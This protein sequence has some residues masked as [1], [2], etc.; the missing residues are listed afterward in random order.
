MKTFL[1]ATSVLVGLVG[2]ICGL[3]QATFAYDLKISH[4]EARDTLLEMLKDPAMN[5]GE[6]KGESKLIQ[7]LHSYRTQ[8][9]P[10]TPVIQDGPF[11]GFVLQN[12]IVSGWSDIYD[13]QYQDE[14]KKNVTDITYGGMLDILMQ[15]IESGKLPDEIK[16]VGEQ[17]GMC[18]AKKVEAADESCKLD[19]SDTIPK[20][21]SILKLGWMK[22]TCDMPVLSAT[23]SPC[24]ARKAIFAFAQTGIVRV[25][26][27]PEP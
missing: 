14:Y 21:P 13:G 22:Y 6:A 1:Q 5:S 2:T 7:V 24:N 25:V 16:G 20:K 4:G 26:I 3:A 19:N 8:Q 15:A 18:L 9:S 11:V 12:Q 10:G 23:T 27:R 17:I